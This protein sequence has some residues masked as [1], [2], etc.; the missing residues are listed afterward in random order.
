VLV[1]VTAAL[2][3]FRG[4]LLD[5]EFLEGWDVAHLNLPAITDREAIEGEF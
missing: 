5:I 1:L 2:H 3:E 4:D